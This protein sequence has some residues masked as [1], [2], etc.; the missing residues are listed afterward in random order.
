MSKQ[1][2]DPV[3]WDNFDPDDLWA[4]AARERLPRSGSLGKDPKPPSSETRPR[5]RVV[6]TESS[7]GRWQRG[8]ALPPA[9]ERV[10]TSSRRV[11]RDADHPSDLWD[12]PADAA[13]AAADFSAFGAIPDDPKAKSSS[14]GGD[15]FDFD[16]MTEATRQFELERQKGTASEEEEHA[17]SVQI[18]PKRPLA[19]A[20]TTI[21]SGSGDDVNVFEDFDD[22]EDPAVQK[23]VDT[24]ASSRLMQMIGV[25]NNDAAAAAPEAAPAAEPPAPAAAPSWGAVSET[26]QPES[27][28]PMSSSSIS[29]NPWGAPIG[30]GTQQQGGLDLAARLEAVVSEQKAREAQV[31]VELERRQR[32]EAD[33]RRRQQEEAQ[34]RAM[35]A[36]KQDVPPQQPQGGH[37]QVEIVLVER[38][39]TILEKS[40]GRSDLAS[41]LATLH[42]EDSRVIP[43][44]GNIDALRALIAR[45]PRRIALRHDPSF[46]AEMVTLLLSNTQWQQQQQQ[47][48]AQLAQARAQQEEMQR[49][50]QQRLMQ[51]AAAREK[52]QAL[53]PILPDAPWFYSDPQKN[54]QGPFRGEEMRQWFE[55]GYFKGDL[56]ISQQPTGPFVPLSTLFPNES[57][58]FKVPGGDTVDDSA[59]KAEAAAKAA[60]EEAAAQERR[61]AEEKARAEAAAAQARA[62]EAEEKARA[63]AAAATEKAAAERNQSANQLKMM[64][65]VGT[66]AGAA[67]VEQAPPPERTEAPAP[68]PSRKKDKGSSKSNDKANKAAQKSSNATAPAPVPQ[69]PTST[70][71]PAWGGAKVA[72]TRK[73]MSEIQQEEARA[74]A[75]LAMERK[76]NPR[77]SSGG[78]ANIA[79]SGG[80]S[81]GWSGGAVKATPPAVVTNA[82]VPALKPATQARPTQA[83]AAPKAG[84]PRRQAAPPPPPQAKSQQAVADEFGASMP[85]ALQSWCKDQMKKLNGTDDLTLVSFCMTLTDPVEIRQYLT[86]YLGSSPQVN[87]FATEFIKRKDGKAQQDEWETPVATKK[88]KKKKGGSK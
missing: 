16:N 54:I 37:S 61:A 49:R 11:D 28:D 19:S 72:A 44:L 53:P 73:S 7:S 42:A 13:D 69:A 50:E 18:D 25:N 6:A 55:A 22:D 75:K 47:Q 34:Q 68:A 82:S 40:W 77:S 14:G 43:L 9:D 32:E 87:N 84:A 83:A 15:A 41:I 27:Q 60:A 52:A 78:W 64:L 57:V 21:Q 24:S 62:Q 3:C 80:G 33:L 86:A 81:S 88:G 58:A 30:G 63:A 10:S 59:A 39:S 48:Q 45:H 51:E 56:P 35:Q 29:M 26:S 36:Q 79:A 20:G 85:P 66:T 74:A 1:P 8:V 46:G 4:Q 70:P 65:G 31:A 5:A 12:D 2:Q 71:S 17:H 38:I 76:N 23:G 67:P